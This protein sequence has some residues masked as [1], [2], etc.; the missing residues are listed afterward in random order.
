MDV[1][2]ADLELITR[3]PDGP[4]VGAPILLVHGAWHGAW[5]WEETF[6]P[7][8]ASRGRRVLAVSLRGHGK[9][10]LRGSLRRV[11][12]RDYVDDV[13]RTVAAIEP[14]PV[15][16][17][18]S[19]GGLVVQKLLEAPQA[20]AAVLLGSVPPRGP[21]GASFRVARRMP[22]TF[23]RANLTLSLYPLVATPSRARTVLFSRGTPVATVEGVAPRLQDESYLAY[24]DMLLFARPDPRKVR[25]PILV[26]GGSDDLLFPP[27]DARVT[28][29]AYGTEARIIPDTGHDAMLEPRWQE[30]AAAMLAWL[31]ERGV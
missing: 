1:D 2:G 14:A 25:T 18:H 4:Q 7:Y 31:A 16:V 9:S 24:L 8:L 27:R 22:L 20:P 26:I 19:M 5:A 11:R 30:A 21:W 6:L 17:G 10:P 23:L 3:E 15:I 13:R 29:K 28:A 12:I